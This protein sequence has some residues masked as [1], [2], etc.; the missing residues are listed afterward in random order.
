MKKLWKKLLAVTTAVM[1]AITLLPAMAN[2]T[3]T[4]IEPAGT[5]TIIKN[6]ENQNKY[7]AG[8]QFSFYKIAS[9]TNLEGKDWKYTVQPNY[10]GELKDDGN[11]KNLNNLPSSEWEANIDTLAAIDVVPTKKSNLSA[12]KTGSTGKTTLPLGVYLVKE[13]TTPQGYVASKPFIV[14]VPSTN[15]YNNG[16]KGT[17]FIYDIIAQPKNSKMSVDKT[18]VDEDKTAY[19]GQ[20][21][22][23]KVET[24]IPKYGTEYT[25]PVFNIYDKMSNGLSFVNDDN[26]TEHKLK[27]FVDGT[28]ITEKTDTY[29]LKTSGLSDGKTFEIQFA[30]AFLKS[31]ENKEKKV[32]VI[33]YAKVND[34]AVYIN[35]NSANI[36]YQNKPGTTTDATPSEKNV[37]TYGIDLKKT[38][39]KS[40]DANGLDGAEF[41]LA[42]ANGEMISILVN[43]TKVDVNGNSK[44]KFRTTIVGNKKGKL[45]FKGLK[46]GIYTLT[47]TKSPSGYSLA[48]NPITI[49]ITAKEDGS[50]ADATVDGISVKNNMAEDGVVPVE[51][52]NKSG[53]N[54]PA[55]GGMG[56]YLFTIGG[57][58]IM[59]GAALLLIA[60]KK[61][62]A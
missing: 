14:S 8:A 53:F 48:K 42:V 18:I 49:V 41:T 36:T 34:K 59:A 19:I 16:D 55:T 3:E 60:S 62:R 54:L 51:L 26:D 47:E 13:T 40:V 31:E 29:T 9:I 20:F 61:R 27:V 1:M 2:A 35:K 23:Y 58:V 43:G 24:Q 57:L 37:Y 45:V 7:L 44:D 17:E 12:E 5:V 11:P 30:E 6:G 56:T 52:Q 50:L 25:N 32:E 28:E 22:K 15:N 33:Y 38:G 46:A 39:D 10:K 4:E 21:V